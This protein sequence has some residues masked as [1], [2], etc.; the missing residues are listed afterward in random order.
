MARSKSK[1]QKKARG[2]KSDSTDAIELLKA[3][4]RTV[5]A[6]FEDYE[7]LAE[8]EAAADE[9]QELANQICMELTVHA[10]I[11]EELLYPALREAFEAQD[12]ID[13]AVVEHATAKDLI[14]QIEEM[15]P[16]EELYDAK[17][18]VLGEYIKHHAQEEE[19]EIFKMARKCD[20]DMEALGASLSARRDELREDMGLEGSADASNEAEDDEDDDDE[21]EETSTARRSERA[22]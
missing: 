17:V 2:A 19:S 13:E 1:T 10:Q 22:K 16:D 3:D 8:G 14:E 12:L 11:E 15:S 20:I 4:H 5:T 6:L 9:R 21:E 7:K 18:R